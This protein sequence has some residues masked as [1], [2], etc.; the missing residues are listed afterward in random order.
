MPDSLETTGGWQP[1]QRTTIAEPG[2]IGDLVRSVLAQV[3][4]SLSSASAVY[5]S[6]GSTTTAGTT[7]SSLQVAPGTNLMRLANT[8]TESTSAEFS[9]MVVFGGVGL[10]TWWQP[11]LH[12]YGEPVA[13][14]EPAAAVTLSAFVTYGAAA[15]DTR[16]KAFWS[17][18]PRGLARYGHLR[19]RFDELADRWAA[20]SE[21]ISSHTRAIL[22]RP[23]Q[24]IIGLGPAVVPLLLERL[25]DRPDHWFWALSILTD[26]DPAD[27]AHG[28]VEAREA[29]LSWGRSHGYIR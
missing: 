8:S 21:F 12:V 19:T 6:V 11:L 23:Y 16:P 20:E 24:Q 2:Q 29:W 4:W 1:E 25:R 5:G 26:Q 10:A 18:V 15:L 28:F 14:T 17:A 13:H 7:E 9:E 3:D 22:L 27:G